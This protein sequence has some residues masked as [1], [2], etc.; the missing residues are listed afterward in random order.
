MRASCKKNTEI[1]LPYIDIFICSFDIK[2]QIS[3]HFN[4]FTFHPNRNKFIHILNTLCIYSTIVLQYFLKE[5]FHSSILTIWFIWNSCI[6]DKQRNTAFFTTIGKIRPD[7]RFYYNRNLR[8]YSCQEPVYRK[9]HIKREVS[10][11]ICQFRIFFLC[12]LLASVCK[13]RYYN[14]IFRKVCTNRFKQIFYC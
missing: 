12:N 5:K 9:R 3:H 2:F 7:F 13:C 11:I 4:I 1:F 8:F 10:N 14:F 6:Y